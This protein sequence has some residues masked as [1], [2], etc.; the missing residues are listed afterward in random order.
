MFLI[1]VKQLGIQKILRVVPSSVFRLCFLKKPFLT[2]NIVTDGSS[3]DGDAVAA[4]GEDAGKSLVI[5]EKASSFSIHPGR[6]CKDECSNCNTKFGI[7]DTPQHIAQLKGVDRQNNI[8]QSNIL[9]GYVLD[10]NLQYFLPDELKLTRDSCLC[11]ACY[12][13]VD[14]KANT[15]S[16]SSKGS[17]RNNLITPRQ[18]Y[19]H[20]LGCNKQA[21]NILRRK[22]IIKMRKSICHTVSYTNDHVWLATNVFFYITQVNIDLDNPGLHSIP[23]CDDHYSLVE[24]LMVCSMCKRRL[25]PNHIHYMGPETTELNKI[26]NDMNIPVSLNDSLA[27]CKCCKLFATLALRLPEER[28]R[29]DGCF[30]DQYKRRQV[31]FL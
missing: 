13:H 25:A 23:L 8:L 28:S 16:Y 24:I 3:E 14:R 7:F 21:S 9:L 2:P 4:E 20:V 17:K 29:N 12:R 30:F 11:D 26:L 22:V 18:N 19:C 15:P 6:V 5:P 27:V 1:S 10:N 31:C